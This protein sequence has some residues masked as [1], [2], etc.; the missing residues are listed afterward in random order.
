MWDHFRL[1]L[2]WASYITFVVNSQ[3]V[4]LT[5]IKPFL[6]EDVENVLV[7]TPRQ[8]ALARN[9]TKMK[10]KR[11]R[12]NY[13]EIMKECKLFKIHSFPAHHILS[14][15]RRCTVKWS[16]ELGKSTTIS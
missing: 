13:D 9:F 3:S 12:K 15:R 4:G 7:L 5:R 11:R 1:K 6:A 2:Q 10:E 8:E 14:R 16:T